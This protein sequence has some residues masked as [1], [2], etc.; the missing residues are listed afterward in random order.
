MYCSIYVWTDFHTLMW[1]DVGARGQSVTFQ[2][3]STFVFE[4][5]SLYDLGAY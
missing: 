5:G 4:T 1:M 2:M 3:S